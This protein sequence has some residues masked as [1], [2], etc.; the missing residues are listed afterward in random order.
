MLTPYYQ[1]EY[2]TIY[3][4]DCRDIIPLLSK[5]DLVLT[6]P[7]YGVNIGHHGAANE[8]RGWLAK[9]AYASYD[10]TP[11]NFVRIIV[12]AIKMALQICD[13][14]I[15]FCAGTQLGLLPSYQALGGVFLPAGMG[16]TCW[17][18]Q[19]FAFAALYGQA[20]NLNLGAHPSGISSVERSERN[21]HP[22]PK[23]IGWMLWAV[24]LGSLI[25]HSILDPFMGSGTTLRAA[26]DLGRYSIGIEIDEKYCEIAAQRLSQ[27]VLPLDRNCRQ[28]EPMCRYS[29]ARPDPAEPGNN[30]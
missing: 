15:I 13:R 27:E 16:R 18:F 10:D 4:G 22:C 17:G 25:G 5:V 3:H 20:P 12:P 14:A 6:D 9:G 7:P 24:S 2:A 29:A 1:D 23:P 28:S 30:E 19:N 21:G 11:E 26:K 8:T